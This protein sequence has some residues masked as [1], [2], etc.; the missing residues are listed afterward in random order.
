MQI[1]NRDFLWKREH[2]SNGALTP[3]LRLEF[4]VATSQSYNWWKPCCHQVW[5]L[6]PGTDRSCFSSER[7]VT[8]SLA[9]VSLT[10]W[11][12]GAAPFCL[13]LPSNKNTSTATH[14]SSNPMWAYAFLIHFPTESKFFCPSAIA[15]LWASSS[16]A[17]EL[18]GAKRYPLNIRLNHSFWKLCLG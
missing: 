16:L 10:S 7:R 15:H 12:G 8:F 13:F 1:W 3:R 9:L 4:L 2:P 11:P 18:A 17:Q 6:P 5:Y 14:D